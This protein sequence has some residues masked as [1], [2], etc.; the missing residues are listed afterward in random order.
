MTSPL[1]SR[2]LRAV[3]HRI[4]WWLLANQVKGARGEAT[5][6]V[7]HGWRARAMRELGI[8]KNVLYNAERRLKD[9][10]IIEARRFQRNVRLR[11]QAF[12]LNH[13]EDQ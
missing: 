7:P 13:R 9:A 10:S 11:G 6:T 5:G 2:S 4:V 1:L 3:D 8:A 12:E